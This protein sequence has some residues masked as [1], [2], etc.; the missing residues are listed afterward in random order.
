MPVARHNCVHG[1]LALLEGTGLHLWESPARACKCSRALLQW[2]A[3]KHTL[4]NTSRMSARSFSSII[5]CRAHPYITM[6]QR[7]AAPSY[8]SQRT[9]ALSP[10]PQRTAAQAHFR[11]H[12]APPTHTS[13]RSAARLWL[14]C[15]TAPASAAKAFSPP[16]HSAGLWRHKPVNKAPQHH[17][18]STAASQLQ[19]QHV[20]ATS[21]LPQDC[22]LRPA[23]PPL[24]MLVAALEDLPETGPAGFDSVSWTPSVSFW[25][26]TPRGRHPCVSCPG[27]A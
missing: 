5:Y 7:T 26:C 21:P 14:S 20:K 23:D 12:T 8:M 13:W 24:L 17:C 6:S 18:P 10:M 1:P 25:L 9:A 11:Q 2:A 16:S 22:C 19:S 27:S 4:H 15:C 3:S